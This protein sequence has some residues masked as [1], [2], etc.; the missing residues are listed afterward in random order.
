MALEK[1]DGSFWED[2]S[3][4]ESE[5]ES[6]RASPSRQRQPVHSEQLNGSVAKL[7]TGVDD[8]YPYSSA[9]SS[10]SPEQSQPGLPAMRVPL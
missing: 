9:A 6:G 4:E 2:Q 1:D 10:S 8:V 3:V 5:A 7:E